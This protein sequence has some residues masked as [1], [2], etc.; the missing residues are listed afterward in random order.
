MLLGNMLFD[1][2]KYLGWSLRRERHVSHKPSLFLELND[3]SRVL[4]KVQHR[5]ISSPDD[6]EV[7]A[8]A[9]DAPE[10]DFVNVSFR[11]RAPRYSPTEQ[12]ELEIH[13][14]RRYANRQDAVIQCTENEKR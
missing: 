6:S 7:Y 11:D 8:G 10:R 5:P 1:N 13:S 3:Y 9:A 12:A 4:K 14:C 2:T